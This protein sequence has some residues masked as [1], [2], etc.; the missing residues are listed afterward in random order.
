[1]SK[2]RVIVEPYPWSVPRGCHPPVT[3]GKVERFQQTLKKW[4]THQPAAPTQA[5]LQTQLDQFATLYMKRPRFSAALIRVA[6]L[7]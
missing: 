6:A 4:L 5:D 2:N 7:G 3:Q 1:M